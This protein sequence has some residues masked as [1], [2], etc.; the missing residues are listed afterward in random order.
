LFSVAFVS[1]KSDEEED[2]PASDEAGGSAPEKAPE[3]K[4]SPSDKPDKPD[5]SSLPP[6]RPSAPP[7]PPAGTG[8]TFNYRILFAALWIASQVALVVTA[9]R[10][11]DGAFG[12]R[13]FAESSS[14]KLVLYRELDSGKRVHVDGGVWTARSVDG[15]IHRLTWYDRVPMPYWIFD[16]DMHA[17]YG[18][19]TQLWRLQGA[20]DDVATHIPNDAETRRF[21]LDVTVKKNGHEPV[22]HQ[23]TSRE[24]DVVLY[25]PPPREE[26]LPDKQL[27]LQ[28]QLQQD[29]GP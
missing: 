13:M 29:G 8:S 12:F 28:Q 3:N 14:I 24:R 27:Q 11:I 17:S 18:A 5:K 7:P 9:D 26:I 19:G 15:T 20:L 21:V 25:L 2:A 10:R 16:Q 1:G 23:L 22:V 4:A 6:V